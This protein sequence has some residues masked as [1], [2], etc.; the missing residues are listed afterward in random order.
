MRNTGQCK[1]IM[2]LVLSGVSQGSIIALSPLLEL[3]GLRGRGY[4]IFGIKGGGGRNVRTP[5]ILRGGNQF[6]R[7]FSSNVDKSKKFLC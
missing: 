6:G 4:E 2:K 1:V 5:K 7:C 3:F